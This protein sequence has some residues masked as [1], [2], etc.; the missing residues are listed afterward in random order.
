MP[1]AQCK[2]QKKTKKIVF[3]LFHLAQVHACLTSNSLHSRWLQAFVLRDFHLFQVE[4]STFGPLGWAILMATYCIIP[5]LKAGIIG[6]FQLK[7]RNELKYLNMSFSCTVDL[8]LGSMFLGADFCHI[9]LNDKLG[10]TYYF[11][12]NGKICWLPSTINSNLVQTEA[13]MATHS[14]LELMIVMSH[15]ILFYVLSWCLH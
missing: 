5:T 7:E 15:L 10:F 14:S 2:R 11:S 12:Q 6:S 13:L 9:L 1:N 8:Q 3:F 4:V